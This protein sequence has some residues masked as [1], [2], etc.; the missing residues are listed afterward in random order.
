MQLH[1]PRLEDGA[2][3][4]LLDALTAALLR[5]R[6]VPDTAQARENVWAFVTPLA[7]GTRRCLARVAVVGGS[8]DDEAKAGL[9]G[10]F[11]AA[12]RAVL[13]DPRVWVIV[14]EVPDGNW[15]ADGEITRLADAQAILGA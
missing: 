4:E 14:D 12:L 10:D 3:A 1:L 7:P 6:G 2:Q 8:M 5:R 13:P 15:G 11:T 9:V